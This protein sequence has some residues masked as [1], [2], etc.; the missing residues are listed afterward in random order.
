MTLHIY[1]IDYKNKF[2]SGIYGDEGKIKAT[3]I[4]YLYCR[5]DEGNK[6]VKQIKNFYPYFYIPDNTNIPPELHKYIVNVE[7]NEFYTLGNAKMKKVI[8]YNPKNVKKMREILEGY[9]IDVFEGDVV[10]VLRFLIDNK[11]KLEEKGFDLKTNGTSRNLWLDIETGT[12]GG[13]PSPKEASEPITC[14]GCWDSYKEEYTIFVWHPEFGKIKDLSFESAN[15]IPYPSEEHMLR[16]FLEYY[17]RINP[18]LVG[19]WN[20]NSFDIPFLINRLK[21]LRMDA[22]ELSPNNVYGKSGAWVWEADEGKYLNPQIDGVVL[23]DL[24]KYYKKINLAQIPSYS[25]E[26][27][28]QEEFGEGKIEDPRDP[29]ELWKEDPEKLVEY[30]IKDVEL[31]VRIEQKRELVNFVDS[32]RQMVGCNFSDF[33]YFSRLVDIFVL[34]QAK[35]KNI[36]L[37]S[38][39]KLTGPYIPRDK[40]DARYTGAHVYAKPGLYDYVAALDLATLYPNIIRSMNI[41]YDTFREDGSGEI[42]IG[43]NSYSKEP[44]FLPL[45]IED[46]LKISKGYKKLRNEADPT[47]TRYKVLANL[48]E[49]SKFVV[50]AYYG[51]QASESFR[52]YN[53]KNA[54]S[55][56]KIGRDI[57]KFTQEVA[58]NEGH[59]V[60]LIDTDSTYIKLNHSNETA[61]QSLKEGKRLAELINEK[62]GDFVERYGV[63]RDKHTFRIELE[64]LFSKLLVGT[65]KRYAGTMIWDD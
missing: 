31:C 50:N 11:E 8:T 23:F 29:G 30:N 33:Y 56:T 27:V 32:L 1:Q 4:I 10:Y 53:I 46:L 38:K 58:E 28:G 20:S 35:K 51:V 21:N 7:Q 14:I 3:P 26:N 57:I 60:V 48:Y 43:N 25:L 41:S 64:K 49:A 47:T 59:E 52:L 54:E 24:F 34:K 22:N 17:N 44:G 42:K 15:V 40:R 19:G 12:E 5:D 13:F 36:I 62:Y 6:V 37:P 61:E 65:K 39:G 18:D 63:S 9:G 16:G 55:I 45:A 2:P